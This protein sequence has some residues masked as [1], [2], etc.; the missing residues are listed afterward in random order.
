MAIVCFAF[1][2]FLLGSLCGQ[3]RRQT[4]PIS[5]IKTKVDTVL[6][7]DT[8][9][10]IKPISVEKQIVERQLV[11]VS[12]TVRVHDTLFVYL[13]REQV[14]W[15][16]SLAVVY[17]SG[18]LPQVDSVKHFRESKVVTIETAYPYKV[19]SRWGLGLQAGM[20]AGK[21]GLSPYVGVGLSYNLLSW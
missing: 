15:Q 20:S 19:R 8:I 11:S 13:D 18:I 6:I 17:A 12:D 7:F 2:V 14:V 3:R 9:T 1:A 10:Q 5:P 4:L 21:D 16:D